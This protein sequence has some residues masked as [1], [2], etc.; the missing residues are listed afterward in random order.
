MNHG[1]AYVQIVMKKMQNR[2]QNHKKMRHFGVAFLKKPL[3]KGIYRFHMEKLHKI[4]TFVFP[5]GCPGIEEFQ[6]VLFV[7]AFDVFWPP[8]HFEIEPPSRH[9]INFHNI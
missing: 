9:R 5:A 3:F 2:R 7:D 6:N 8:P 1:N 4:A